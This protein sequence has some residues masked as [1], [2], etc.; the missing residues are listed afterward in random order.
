MAGSD[1]ESEAVFDGDFM[2]DHLD[3]DPV[4]IKSKC[5][6]CADFGLRCKNCETEIPR[7][8]KQRLCD[9]CS[10][11]KNLTDEDS[12]LEYSTDEIGSLITSILFS[13]V[14]CLWIGLIGETPCWI[15][16][17]NIVSAS[18]VAMAL[19]ILMYR[20]CRGST[21]TG[22]F[23]LDN[24]VLHISWLTQLV[25]NASLMFEMF[26]MY[27]FFERNIIYQ[28]YYPHLN[29]DE[30]TPAHCVVYLDLL[31]NSIV[32]FFATIAINTACIRRVKETYNEKFPLHVDPMKTPAAA[33]RYEELL[34]KSQIN[35][36]DKIKKDV[37]IADYT[38]SL[39]KGY[40]NAMVDLFNKHEGDDFIFKL[41]FDAFSKIRLLL[42]QDV[43]T[44]GFGSGWFRVHSMSRSK[45]QYFESIKAV[46]LLL[47]VWTFSI[48]SAG[49]SCLINRKVFHEVLKQQ[50]LQLISIILT[51]LFCCWLMQR[52]CSTLYKV[53]FVYFKAYAAM[54]ICT[55]LQKD[56][57]SPIKSSDAWI[58]AA[59]A[60]FDLRGYVLGNTIPFIYEILTPILSLVVASLFVSTFFWIHQFVAVCNNDIEEL[61]ASIFADNIRFILFSFTVFVVVLNM[62]ILNCVFTPFAE[63]QEHID[64]MKKIRSAFYI[65]LQ[66]AYQLTNR[67]VTK[68]RLRA[69]INMC[70][71]LISLMKSYQLN[72]ANSPT[73]F[74]LELTETKL[75]AMRGYIFTVIAFF[76]ASIFKE[77]LAMIP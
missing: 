53:S 17:A 59:E 5:F 52:L 19:L 55:V 69:N 36:T 39:R 62:M 21:Y 43:S 61:F 1:D 67:T 68:K 8:D 57:L 63:Q 32:V 7:H 2:F 54:K 44:T 35:M 73:V 38:P 45:S 75:M 37:T 58:S 74:G 27:Y 29:H 49:S 3:F 13:P 71:H 34:K 56:A 47:L 65:Q 16:I 24:N 30:E 28:C 40:D 50:P 9:Q 23:G 48:V 72:S 51:S 66:K 25:L 60:W 6:P 46:S 64:G 12:Q 33:A 42:F 31:G 70:D 22:H 26:R 76:G 20:K 11:I 15:L 14:P 4:K 10:I 18:M 41:L 77:W